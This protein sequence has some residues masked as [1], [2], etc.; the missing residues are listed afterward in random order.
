M[1]VCARA[2]SFPMCMCANVHIILLWVVNLL[3]HVIIVCVCVCICTYSTHGP[4]SSITVCQMTSL[5]VDFTAQCMCRSF[6]TV[7]P[8]V[9]LFF[10]L[11]PHLHDV[12]KEGPSSIQK[13]TPLCAEGAKCNNGRLDDGDGK[14]K[15]AD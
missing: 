3:H 7:C 5:S 15:T 11:H 6:D 2:L 13:I 8:W 10:V 1:C 14:R 9:C 12:N 4:I